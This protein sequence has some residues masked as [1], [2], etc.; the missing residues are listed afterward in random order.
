LQYFYGTYSDGERKTDTYNSLPDAVRAMS[1]DIMGHT[2]VHIKDENSEVV[3]AIEGGF[4]PKLP[5]SERAIENVS[6]DAV[7]AFLDTY[8]DTLF[9]TIIKDPKTSAISFN[10]GASA[11]YD[12]GIITIKDATGKPRKI[13]KV[14]IETVEMVK[15]KFSKQLVCEACGK[16]M[17]EI[18][19]PAGLCEQEG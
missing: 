18:P 8:K 3:W 16:H 4:Y 14:S 6:G 13:L 17:G 1:R 2:L 5:M 7:V 9:Q 11:S 19:E 10:T 12:K 15:H